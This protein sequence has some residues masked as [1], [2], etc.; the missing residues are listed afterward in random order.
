[1]LLVN[2][3]EPIVLPNHLIRFRRRILSAAGPQM[4]LNR[5]EQILRSA[6]VKEKDSLPEAP[7]GRRTK[8]VAPRVPLTDIV[9]QTSTHIVKDQIGI[10]V[11]IFIP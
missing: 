8:F 3:A 10:Q 1:M 5:L 2:F 6:V 4:G 7:Q 11:D 9:S